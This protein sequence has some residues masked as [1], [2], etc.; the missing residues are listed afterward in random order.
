MKILHTESSNGW[1][2]QEIRILK[3]S[4]GLKERGHEIVFVVQKGGGLVFKAKGQGFVVYEIDFKKKRA[5]FAIWSL[6][7]I[8]RRHQIEIINTHSSLD[9]WLG[10]IAGRLSRKKV[11]RTRH[12]ST[13]IRNGINSLLLYNKLA[14][15]VV[16]TSS[17]IIPMICAQAKITEKRCRCVATGVDV[18]QVQQED[19]LAFRRSIG[20]TA[21]DCLVGTVCVVRSWKGILDLMKA[22][23]L[24]RNK[25]SIKWVVIGGGYLDQYQDKIDLKGVLTFTGH[26]DF[27]FAAMAALDIFVLL[28]TANEGISQASLQASCLEKPLITTTIGG[29]PEVCLE[30]KT[31]FLV[32]PFSPEK[33]VEAVQKL[34]ENKQLRLQ[35]GKKAKEHVLEHFTLKQTLDKMEE[36]YSEV[37]S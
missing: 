16:T 23:D 1:G 14:D 21:E 27:P 7:K 31:G 18:P 30:G 24:M 20:A 34:Y 29:L 32:P 25:K 19:I 12:L 5:L 6:V 3:E 11:V 37:Y 13:P 8:I 35:M 9:G 28:S 33:V 17:G 36:I 10:G 4:L 22:A 2:G 26:L 15:F